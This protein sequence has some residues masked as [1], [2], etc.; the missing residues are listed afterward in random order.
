[1]GDGC[2]K[3]SAGLVNSTCASFYTL[4][5]EKKEQED[6][7]DILCHVNSR[8]KRDTLSMLYAKAAK[9]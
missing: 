8:N 3:Y 5:D 4:Q 9:R 6:T 2:S 7:I 1:M